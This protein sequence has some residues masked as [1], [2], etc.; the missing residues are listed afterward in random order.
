MEVIDTFFIGETG[1]RYFAALSMARRIVD[2]NDTE[3]SVHKA[4]RIVRLN[5]AKRSEEP[6]C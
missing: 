4:P 1:V 5:G 6:G 2:H 3:N